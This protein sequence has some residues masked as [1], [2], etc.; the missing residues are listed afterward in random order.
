MGEVAIGTKHK[1]VAHVGDA[2]TLLAFDLIDEA[3]RTDLAGF[4]VQVGP[5]GRPAYCL[6]NN[7][8]FETPGDHAQDPSEPTYSS[9]NAPI[10]KFRWIHVPGLD[11][12][13]L[14]AP[15]GDYTYTVTPRYFDGQRRMTALDPALSVSVTVPLAPFRKGSLT[16][17]FTR[18]FVQ[19][20]AFVRHFGNKLPTRPKDGPLDYDTSQEAGTT[21]DGQRFTYAD[22]YRW[23]GSTARERIM[24]V[25][26]SVDADANAKIDVF[27]YDLNEPDVVRLLVKLGR[28]GKARI[29]LDNADLHHDASDPTPEDQFEE[30]FAQAAGADRI[31]RGRFGRYAHDKVFVVYRNGAPALL[32]TGSTNFSVTGVYVNSNHVLVFNDPD[33]SSTY[34]KLFDEAFATRANRPHFLAT[35]LASETFAFQDPTFDLTLSPRSPADAAARLQQ[36]VDRCQEEADQGG[37]VLFAVMELS[38]TSPNPVYEALTKL[39]R[40]D[41][42]F[43]YGISDH[44]EG[45]SFYPIGAKNGVLVTGK[46]SSTAL[47]PPFNQV[48]SVGAGHQ[49]HHKFVVCGFGGTDPV[50][51]CGSSNLALAGEQVNGDNLLCIHDADVVTAF[52]IEALLLIDHFNFLDSTAK[53]PK[54]KGLAAKDVPP[55]ADGRKAAA[56]AG[57]H[58]GVTDAWAS[59]YFD[60]NDLHRRD[61][62]MFADAGAP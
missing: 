34:A 49:V 52:T 56:K 48:P 55:A 11:H 50:V 19:S 31:V 53:A 40:D 9:I 28:D 7:L 58:L 57:W 2:K 22:Q 32:L 39:H 61:R 42:L 5:P 24:E 59:K 4:T 36:I 13:G 45:I 43:S 60:P 18:G 41:R 26:T 47:P 37:N 23:L 3:S 62:V 14:N 46:P 44:P 15:D 8:S 33:V 35:T 1:V 54:G 27:A 12:Q 30:M 29:V 38:S 6:W 51:F 20:Q 16:L 17:G 21:P 10:H 25:L